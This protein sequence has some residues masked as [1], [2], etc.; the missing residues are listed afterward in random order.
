MIVRA[1]N[2]FNKFAMNFRRMK[3]YLIAR[4]GSRKKGPNWQVYELCEVLIGFFVWF[5]EL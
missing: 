3:K 4:F 1:K 5:L 2:A